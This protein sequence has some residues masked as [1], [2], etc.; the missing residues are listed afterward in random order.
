MTM[1]DIPATKFSP[2]VV[3][4][5]ENKTCSISGECYPENSFV[6]F[7]PIFQWL[8]AGLPRIRELTFQVNIPYMNSSSAKCMLDILDLLDEAARQGCMV[9]VVWYYERGNERALDLAE[10]FCEDIGIP[11]DIVPFEETGSP[12]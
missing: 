9:K 5:E 12:S 11:F 1:I 7:E 2:R 10:E 8:H 4:S 3:I 6:F